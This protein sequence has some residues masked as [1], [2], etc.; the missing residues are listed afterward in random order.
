MLSQLGY[1]ALPGEL[2]EKLYDG[3][4]LTPAEL[5]LSE[6]VPLV[7][8]K[9][10]GHI[11]RLEPVLQ[12]LN[13]VTASDAE[14]ASLGEGTVGLGARMPGLVLQYDT[15]VAQ[16]LSSDVAMQT[17]RVKSAR[18][19]AAL[20][21]QSAALVGAAAGAAEIRE[22]PLRMVQPGMTVIHDLRTPQGTLLIPRGFEVSESFLQRLRNFGSHILAEKVKVIVHGPAPAR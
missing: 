16:G 11:P 2:V 18:H 15:V 9:L 1:L 22:I 17:V 3:Q 14:I 10:L 4:R 20:V 12:I 21:E 19:G 6:G 5:A 7:A 13:A 8:N